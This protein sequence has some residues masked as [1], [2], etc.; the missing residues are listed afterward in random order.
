MPLRYDTFQVNLAIAVHLPNVKRVV[1]ITHR[2]CGAAA[3]A[4]G[5]RLKTDAAW[6][7]G[8]RQPQIIV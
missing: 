3:V 5:D 2:D 7:T 1:G 6:E 8:K 4:C